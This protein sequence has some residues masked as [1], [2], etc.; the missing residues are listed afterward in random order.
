MEHY[1]NKG[2]ENHLHGEQ[3]QSGE[4]EYPPE[5]QVIFDRFRN[6]ILTNDKQI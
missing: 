1:L 2:K 4:K 6:L 3:P 5:L